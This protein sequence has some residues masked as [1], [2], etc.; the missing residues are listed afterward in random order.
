MNIDTTT[1]MPN[2]STINSSVLKETFIPSI[3]KLQQGT[4]NA[5]NSS[6]S[7]D[8]NYGQYIS[9]SSTSPDFVGGQYISDSSTSPDFGGGQH[10]IGET[11]K[12]IDAVNN[13]MFKRE[14]KH[15]L[16]GFFVVL[17]ICVII[18]VVLYFL[19]PSIEKLILSNDS[20]S[21]IA[22]IITAILILLIVISFLLYTIFEIFI[23]DNLD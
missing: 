4:N 16:M 19:Y 14:W 9:N 21:N 11:E 20:V 18:G 6:T 17:I 23:K 8:L 12:L 15:L 2:S 10:E 22:G 7:P 1:D 5:I 13:E 3:N